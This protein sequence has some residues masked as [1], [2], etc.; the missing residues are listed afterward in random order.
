MML[1]KS[2]S[3]QLRNRCKNHRKPLF[4]SGISATGRISSCCQLVWKEAW[5]TKL[6]MIDWYTCIAMSAL[7]TG[8]FYLY[9]LI[10]WFSLKNFNL[11]VDW[12]V[13]HHLMLYTH[14]RLWS[15]SLIALW[16]ITRILKAQKRRDKG[17]G[18][19][20]IVCWSHPCGDATRA[21]W[22]LSNL[23]A[24]LVGSCQ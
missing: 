7:F 15:I 16:S 13:H 12:V 2:F 11:F 9:C 21:F 3:L 19:K 10:D 6:W 5:M 14:P 17:R 24:G 4:P 1:R 20:I 8:Y 18:Q 23:S 22:V